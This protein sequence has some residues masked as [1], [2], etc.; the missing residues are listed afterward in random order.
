MNEFWR[1]DFTCVECLSEYQSSEF[2]SQDH[3]QNH[4]VKNSSPQNAPLSLADRVKLGR[5]S[6][7]CVAAFINR[8]IHGDSIYYSRSVPCVLAV[9]YNSQE[10][11]LFY[12]I[13]TP[14]VP[15]QCLDTIGFG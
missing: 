10:F 5:R 9:R 11:P 14:L 6:I 15:S 1:E 7:W 8:A 3:D 13:H 4:L 2:I 12:H